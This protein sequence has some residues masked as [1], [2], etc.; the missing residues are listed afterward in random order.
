M[1]VATDVYRDL[2]P[3][4][5]DTRRSG[6]CVLPRARP[7][8]RSQQDGAGE[9]PQKI[10]RWNTA[11]ALLTELVA[12]ERQAGQPL[13]QID[14][15][16]TLTGGELQWPD[17]SAT[18]NYSYRPRGRSGRS[19]DTTGGLVGPRRASGANASTAAAAS[20]STSRSSATST[21]SNA[22]S[23]RS[24]PRQPLLLHGSGRSDDAAIWDGPDG[25]LVH[26]RTRSRTCDRSASSRP[27]W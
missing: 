6:H 5:C 9:H 12:A 26:V 13:I 2:D 3:D 27:W 22:S 10:D 11:D 25:L 15:T 17:V 19:G 4:G 20:T 21:S 24:R 23:R 16:A 8:P 18:A 7:Q 1:H 14:H